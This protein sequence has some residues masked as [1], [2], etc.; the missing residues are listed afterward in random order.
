MHF[1]RV[2]KAEQQETELLGVG[3]RRTWTPGSSGKD[4]MSFQ[5]IW[6]QKA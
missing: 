1:L 3:W 2:E 4:R 5:H 6:G